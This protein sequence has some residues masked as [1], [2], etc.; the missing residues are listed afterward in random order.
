MQTITLAEAIAELDRL[1]YGGKALSPEYPDMWAT[2]AGTA[3]IQLD[4]GEL[5]VATTLGEIRKSIKRTEPEGPEGPAEVGY[6]LER[7]G[8]Y[9]QRITWGW[10]ATGKPAPSKPGPPDS[11]SGAALKG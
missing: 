11:T 10:V 5:I 6:R 1:S 4:G 3:E 2:V 8:A 7:P 9:P